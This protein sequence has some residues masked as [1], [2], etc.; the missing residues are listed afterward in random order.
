M[1]QLSIIIFRDAEGK[2]LLQF[3]DSAA[4]TTPLGW[5]FFGGVAIENESP[6]E[7]V[8][9]ETEE[10]LEIKLKA[11]DVNLLVE[12]QWRSKETGEEKMIYLYECVFPIGWE[13]IVIKEG[14]GAA[15]LSKQEVASLKGASRLAKTFVDECC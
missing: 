13:D 5:S 12:R 7:A 2:I 1:L 14:A 6:V 9:R 4:P 11:E 3:R 10:E 15:F 8:I